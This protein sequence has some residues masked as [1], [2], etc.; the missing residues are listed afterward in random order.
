M[1]DQLTGPLRTF[2]PLLTAL[3]VTWGMDDKTA[4][5]VAGAI[6]MLAMAAWSYYS[7][8]PTR[9][10]QQVAKMPDVEVRV[11]PAAPIEM[12]TLAQNPQIGGI[13]MK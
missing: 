13:V 11:G 10:A 7:N 12:L 9:I 6:I 4:G 8:R 3:L 2:I 1:N 5:F